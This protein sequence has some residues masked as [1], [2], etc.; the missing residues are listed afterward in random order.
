MSGY[1]DAWMYVLFASVSFVFLDKLS[2]QIDPMIALF[3]MSGI[4]II[5]FNALSLKQFK[6]TYA[7]CFNH[8]FLFILMSFALGMDWVGMIYA[9]HVSDPFIAMAALFI[10][11]AIMG[12]S[13]FY[14]NT[15]HKIHLL[16]ISLLIGSLVLL[17]FFYKIRVP[18]SV[19][20]GLTLG[21][22]AGIS[23][24]IYIIC[25]DKLCR[26]GGLSTIQVLA[27]RFWALFI[28]STF[29]LP[30]TG[31]W[32]SI[33]KNFW[34]LL[35]ISLGSLIIPIFFNQQAIN[36]LGPAKTS[37]LISFVPPV[38]YL[39]DAWYNTDFLLINFTVCLLI[40]AALILPKLVTSKRI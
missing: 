15:R 12:F 22:I 34:S 8:K 37:I 26:Q 33:L 11:L 17:Y 25:S 14:K 9:T 24:Y 4:A 16:S 3:V 35:F 5:F 36:K 2:N 21:C 29:F 38:T 27:T 13:Q 23:F 7:V 28:G 19:F 10:S 1:I 31:L 40:T 18:Q 39:F 32:T 6:K 30:Y 20:Y